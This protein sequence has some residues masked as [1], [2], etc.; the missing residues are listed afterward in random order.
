MTPVVP[1]YG[2][3]TLAD[4]L[5]SVG[6][7][8]AVPGC[9]DVLGLPAASRYVVL[10]VDGLG[11]VLP[12][13]ALTAAPE[14]HRAWPTAIRL[15][16][17]V[18]STTV[19]SL[20]SLGT[21]LPPGSHGIAGFSFRRPGGADVFNALLWRDDPDP[22]VVQ[23][24]PSLFERATAAGVVATRV[25]P[26]RFFGSGLTE[27][28]LRGGRF[29]AETDDDGGRIDAVRCAAD[30]GDRTLVYHYVRELDHTGHTLGIGSTAWRRRLALVSTFVGRLRAALSDDVVLLVT[31]DHGML[32]VPGH[33][34]LIAE[35]DPVLTRGVDLLAGEARFR[36]LYTSEPDAV[37]D[38]W[39][40]RL[41]ERAWV[42]TR[43]RA[44][45]E[46]WFGTVDPRVAD[47]FGDVVVAMRSDW[48]VLTT[49][50]PKEHDL[51][52]MHGSLTETEMSVPLLVIT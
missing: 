27:A 43:P 22:L 33:H 11:S 26:I 52:G 42:R 34:R 37:A 12:D 23:P 8:L 40:T 2:T 9:S 1:A 16:A 47:H 32:D 38:R 45:A 35:D 17:G 48:A 21:G 19:T 49:S 41:G 24:H 50:F 6:A 51:V 46:G 28:G 7:R 10:L 13:G 20:S 31:G 15:T 25:L 29:V 5:P 39:A 36:Q 14:L 30:S 18:P 4:L 44:I 3:S